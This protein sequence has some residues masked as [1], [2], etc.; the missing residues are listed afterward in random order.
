MSK[1]KG[2][3]VKQT[4]FGYLGGEHGYDRYT[5]CTEVRSVL[6]FAGVERGAF[7]VREI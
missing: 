3:A 6:F 2:R 1:D 7:Y 5:T 4:H